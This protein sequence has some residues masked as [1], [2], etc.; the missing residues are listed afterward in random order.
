[1]TTNEFLNTIERYGATIIPPCNEQDIISANNELQKIYAARLPAFLKELYKNTGG[2]FLGNGY[3]FGPKEIK[4]RYD[5]FIPSIFEINQDIKNLKQIQGMTIFGRN[6]L[7]WFS[8]DAFGNCF[9]LNNLDLKI[10]KRYS[11]PYQALLDC[12]IAGKL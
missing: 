9:M 2:I 1:M 3:I 6:D 7:F 11:E 5:F 12:L 10:L 8:F 4:V